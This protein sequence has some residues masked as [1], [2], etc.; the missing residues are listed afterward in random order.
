MLKI[1]RKLREGAADTVIDQWESNFAGTMPSNER[2]EQLL[3]LGELPGL[4]DFLANFE[5]SVDIVM[6]GDR[7]W[8]P[9]RA[10][11]Y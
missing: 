8:P 1:G 11:P 3:E 10:Q 9:E 4:A 2:A 5:S 7:V 6:E